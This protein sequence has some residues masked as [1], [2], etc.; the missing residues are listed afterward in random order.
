MLPES[1]ASQRRFAAAHRS[2]R[3]RRSK[4]SAGARR[5][6]SNTT[7]S[8]IG[9]SLLSLVRTT[10]NAFFFVTLKEWE[11]RQTTRRAVSGHQAAREPEARRL[12]EGIAFSFLAAGHSRRRHLRRIHLHPRGPLG[13]GRGVSRRATLN[14]FMA[15]ARKR[16]EIRAPSAPRS[17]PACRSSS[18]RSIATRC[19]SRASPSTMS[20]GRSRRSWAGCSSTT[21][22]ASA[23]SGR[24]TS[25]PKAT[26]ATEPRTSASSTCGTRTATWCRCPR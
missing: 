16:P 19:S 9:F 18:S 2:G 10:Y 13:Q 24:S 23:A 22:T 11:D 7:T 12:P 17:C 5:R 1:P 15:A 14:K 20:T 3:A 21:S 8:V 6:A 25:R 4:R 26:T